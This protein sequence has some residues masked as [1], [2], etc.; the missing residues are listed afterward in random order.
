MKKEEVKYNCKHFEGDIPCKPNK[1]HDVQCNNCSHYEQDINAIIQLNT[2]EET[3]QEIY[4][5]CNFSNSKT[6]EEKTNTET[7]KTKILP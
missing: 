5:I 1:L 2:K 3:L 7:Q 4:K 6:T